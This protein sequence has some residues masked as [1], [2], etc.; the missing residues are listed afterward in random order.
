MAAAG[1]LPAENAQASIVVRVTERTSRVVDFMH[2]KAGTDL[3]QLFAAGPCT[4]DLY[5]TVPS[6]VST[7]PTTYLALKTSMVD[8]LADAFK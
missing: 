8:L 7:I 1:V 2:F 5:R 6:R 3:E 4:S